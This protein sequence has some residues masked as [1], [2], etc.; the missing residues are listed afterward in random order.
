[1]NVWIILRKVIAG[2]SGGLLHVLGLR[3][4]RGEMGVGFPRLEA[5]KLCHQMGH[6][7]EAHHPQQGDSPFVDSGG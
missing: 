7:K 4:L 2:V 6:Q 3:A 1:V 5:S